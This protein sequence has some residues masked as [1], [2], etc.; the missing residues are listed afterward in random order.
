MWKQKVQADG[1]LIILKCKMTYLGL[2]IILKDRGNKLTLDFLPFFLYNP[3]QKI[4]H[5]I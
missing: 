3:F 5:F 1:K 2:L 4:N